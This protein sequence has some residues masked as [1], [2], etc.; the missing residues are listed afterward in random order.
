MK[1]RPE[2]LLQL[3]IPRPMHGVNPRT[4][5]GSTWW[6]EQKKEI[7]ILQDNK[8]AACGRQH[9]DGLEAHE[10]YDIDYNK[11]TM[12]FKEV[13][14]LCFKCHSFVHPGYVKQLIRLGEMS[15]K[16]AAEIMHRG[17]RLLNKA[18]L[19][20]SFTYSGE[21]NWTKWRLVFNGKEYKPKYNSYEVWR[22]HY[23]S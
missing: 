3:P 12:K 22:R 8:C 23:E 5:M 16:E 20:R 19:R 1:A 9:K 15:L 6:N 13:V 17:Y 14:G 10:C 4:I 11:C 21:I 18:N 2:L 7:S